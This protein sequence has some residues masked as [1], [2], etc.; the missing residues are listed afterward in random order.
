M[1]NII[2]RDRRHIYLVATYKC[3]IL[4]ESFIGNI[5]SVIDH[6]GSCND[7]FDL[8]ATASLKSLSIIELAFLS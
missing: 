5:L 7:T 6:N 4:K 8:G 1:V 2:E 3:H